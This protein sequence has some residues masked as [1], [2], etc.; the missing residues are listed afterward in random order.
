M[1]RAYSVDLRRRVI[2]AVQGGLSA[3][4]AA[5]R[6]AIGHSTAVLW[7]RRF[8]EYGERGPRK[9]G[10]P[11]GSRL[12]PHA[13]YLLTLLEQTPDLTLAELVARLKRDREVQVG[14]TAL[15]SFLTRRGLT[16]KKKRRTPPNKSART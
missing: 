14:I 11:P 5:E 9:M 4:Q 8:R 16:F 7:V 1:S 6:F 13:Q 15:W 3:H 2:E 12:D 10:K